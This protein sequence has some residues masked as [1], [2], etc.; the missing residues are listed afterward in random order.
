MAEVR[1]SRIAQAD[2]DAI[3][4]HLLDVAGPSVAVS[5]AEQIQASLNL[6]ADFPG[7]G[8]PR[9]QFGPATRMVSVNP[10]LIFYDGLPRATTAHVLR[11]LDGRRDITSEMIARGRK[12]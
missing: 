1:L 11:I 2:F 10:Y 12:Q 5:Y 7:M 4:D 6:L 8:A 9:Q 3:V